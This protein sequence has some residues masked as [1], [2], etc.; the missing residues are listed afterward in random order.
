MYAG[1]A[2]ALFALAYGRIVPD[3]FGF[4]LSIEF[5][6]MVVLG[7][8]G[9]IRG[10]IA[11]AFFVA[12]LPHVLNHYSDSLP[13]VGESGSGAIGPTQLSRLL[14]GAA[15]VAVLLYAAAQHHHH[16]PH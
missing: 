1:L 10:A 2:G 11:G 9:S 5:L 6:V 15:I 8:L 14:F 12:S 4:V 3:S 13:F 16:H 7:G